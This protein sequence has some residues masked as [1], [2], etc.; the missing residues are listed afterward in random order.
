[1]GLDEEFDTKKIAVMHVAR[2]HCSNDNGEL[3]RIFVLFFITQTEFS[4]SCMTVYWVAS[5]L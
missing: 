3:K 2:I 5:F 1:M 4:I